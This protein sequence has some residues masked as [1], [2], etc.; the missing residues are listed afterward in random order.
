MRH[1]LAEGNAGN[2]NHI[3]WRN[4]FSEEADGYTKQLFSHQRAV[5]G[6]KS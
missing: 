3:R 4:A 2:V 6:S 5:E 1:E